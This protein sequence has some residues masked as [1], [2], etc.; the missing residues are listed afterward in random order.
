MLP[1]IKL[2]Q[3]IHQLFQIN[4]YSQT[5]QSVHYENKKLFGAVIKSRKSKKTK[6]CT[7]DA[8]AIHA[9]VTNDD[10][11]SSEIYWL[12]KQNL[13][14]EKAA[15][16][17]PIVQPHLDAI[18]TTEA[19]FKPTTFKTKIKPNKQFAYIPPIAI[20]FTDT[21]LKSILDYPMV[22]DKID[23]SDQP[24]LESHALPS[25]GRILQ[26]TMPA[27]SRRALQKWKLAKIA[28]LGTDGF[29][30]LTQ[31]NF[32]T[33]SLFHRSIENFLMNKTEP[34]DRPELNTLWSSVQSTLGKVESRPMLSETPLIHPALKYKGVVDCVSLVQ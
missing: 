2:R 23:I 30:K 29:Q 7:Q 14:Q 24:I 5:I 32:D 19:P 27:H 20:P 9:I 21:D 4:F 22:C 25:V 11:C 15:P 12:G 17:N 10:D 33:G 3:R 26:A 6:Q 34:E 16:K 31:Q 8:T 28:E 13:P 1:T 18:E